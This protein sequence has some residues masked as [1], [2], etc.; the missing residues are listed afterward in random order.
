MCSRSIANPLSKVATSI[1]IEFESNH[2]Y[3]QHRDPGATN[4]GTLSKLFKKEVSSEA[5]SNGY[6]WSTAR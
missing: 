2:L 4:T 3:H 5:A 1:G 6:Q